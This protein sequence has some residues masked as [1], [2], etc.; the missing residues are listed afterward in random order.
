MFETGT[1]NP[2]TTVTLPISENYKN[3]QLQEAQ[4][5]GIARN[6]LVNWIDLYGYAP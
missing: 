6:L 4:P 2:P 5:Q 3:S 1:E